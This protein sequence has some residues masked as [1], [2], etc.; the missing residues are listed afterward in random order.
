MR[1]GR[2]PIEPNLGYIDE[3]EDIIVEPVGSTKLVIDKTFEHEEDDFGIA[4]NVKTSDVGTH[5]NGINNRPVDFKTDIRPEDLDPTLGSRCAS[6]TSSE[7]N[8]QTR[9]NEKNE[10][11][12]NFENEK[13]YNDNPTLDED[14]D[15][16]GLDELM[17]ELEEQAEIKETPKPISIKEPVEIEEPKRI[18]VEKAV[19]EELRSNLYTEQEQPAT[20]E[21]PKSDIYLEPEVTECKVP[22]IDSEPIDDMGKEIIMEKVNMEVEQP[23]PK[24]VIEVRQEEIFTLDDVM[25]EEEEALRTPTE[26]TKPK[27]A[28]TAAE[29]V[30]S[31]M[32]DAT[33]EMPTAIGQ[34][35]SM[36]EIIDAMDRVNKV[37]TKGTQVK[38][39]QTTIEVE[40]IEVPIEV[41]TST[42]DIA[43]EDLVLPED[44]PE[45]KVEKEV[46]VGTPFRPNLM[47]FDAEPEEE[48]IDDLD[49]LLQEIGEQELDK[50]IEESDIII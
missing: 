1:T 46:D 27:K 3:L 17:G 49:L 34:V 20:T 50:G 21:Q 25:E 35:E 12:Y 5:S 28:M 33:D 11:D 38:T 47:G 42:D 26:Q 31:L 14:L 8:S 29:L 15:I 18:K 45:V 30:A 32:K 4:V 40:A 41:D 37:V 22:V 19:H 23:T 36:A 16:I 44:I 24:E 43:I 2:G 7:S 48:M 39:G 6:R 13:H 10:S 9:E